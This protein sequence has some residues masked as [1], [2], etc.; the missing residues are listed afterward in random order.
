MYTLL[1]RSANWRISLEEVILIS[2]SKKYRIT[3]PP[4]VDEV[5]LDGSVPDIHWGKIRASTCSTRS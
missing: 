1:T 3:A 5:G 4:A 2:F